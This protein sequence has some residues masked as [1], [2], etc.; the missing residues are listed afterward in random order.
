M[1][2]L[3]VIDFHFFTVNRYVG[4]FISRKDRIDQIGDHAKKFTNVYVKNFGDALDD[5]LLKELFDPYGEI[6]SCKVSTTSYHLNQ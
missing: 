6:V 3:E 1:E 2:S 4:R 5:D